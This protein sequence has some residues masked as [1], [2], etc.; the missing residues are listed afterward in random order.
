M[1]DKYVASINIIPGREGMTRSIAQS[2]T[3]CRVVIDY[4]GVIQNIEEQY[5][6]IFIADILMKI[7]E[8]NVLNNFDEYFFLFFS[9]FCKISSNK[10]KGQSL[11]SK[12]CYPS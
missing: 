12:C 6:G 11:V 8:D 2:A 3:K 1:L 9:N 10:N 4:C 7:F 5:G